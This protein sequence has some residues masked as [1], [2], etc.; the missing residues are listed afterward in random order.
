MLADDFRANHAVGAGA[1]A[2]TFF[3]DQVIDWHDS[4]DA[5]A[6]GLD[7]FAGT[8]PFRNDEFVD[9]NITVRPT[10]II[11]QSCS[12]IPEAPDGMCI[13]PMFTGVARM[14]WMREEKWAE[15]DA[16]WPQSEY[17]VQELEDGCGGFAM[18][19]YGG[20]PQS[21]ARTNDRVFGYMSYKMIENKPA[22]RAD[23]YWGFDPYRFDQGE[24]RKAIRWVLDYFGLIINP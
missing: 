7:L 15:G 4:A 6:G 8:F 24:T 17:T 18:T 9:S 2:D 11:P 14:D 16:G 19:S 1:I 13:E 23:V 12:T 21:G 3:T 20:V 5:A 10:P 22:R